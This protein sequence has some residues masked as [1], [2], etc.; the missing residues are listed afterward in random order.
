MVKLVDTRLLEGRAQAW[1]F[2]SPHPHSLLYRVV[3][4]DVMSNTVLSGSGEVT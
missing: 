2:K 1:E 4:G 3:S